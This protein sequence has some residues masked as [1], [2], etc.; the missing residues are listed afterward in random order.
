[1]IRRPSFPL[2]SRRRPTQK[3]RSWR[4]SRQ[5][6]RAGLHASGG[7]NCSS[8][9]KAASRRS[10]SPSSTFMA[11]LHRQN[12]GTGC[13]VCPEKIPSRTTA[14]PGRMPQGVDHEGGVRARRIPISPESRRSLHRHDEPQDHVH[15]PARGDDR[16]HTPRTRRERIKGAL[17]R[18]RLGGER[19]LWVILLWPAFE[20]LWHAVG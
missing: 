18:C 2:N 16:P 14:Q 7:R 4:A 3:T 20:W 1:M 8:H 12:I 15:H 17:A 19:V 6:T 9:S 10:R 11:R 5:T 13:C